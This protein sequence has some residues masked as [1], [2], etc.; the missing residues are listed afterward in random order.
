[1]KNFIDPKDVKLRMFRIVMLDVIVI[2]LL[3]WLITVQVVPLYP[4]VLIGYPTLLAANFLVIWRASRRRLGLPRKATGI[5]K[6]LWFS[7]ALF[8]TASIVEIVAWT[9][10]PDIRSAVQAI[11]G[12]VLAA[13]AWFL[14]HY[15]RRISKDRAEL[16]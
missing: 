1:M 15:R 5:P 13:Y 10:S 6:L 16:G 12:T 14:V 9:R 8:T 3:A 2:L 7:V 4:T 11:I